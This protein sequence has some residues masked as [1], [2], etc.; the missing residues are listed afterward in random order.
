VDETEARAVIA[1]HLGVPPAMVV[2]A[3]ALAELGADPRDV[4][5]LVLR[6]ERC[7]GIRITDAQAERC[8][9]VRDLLDAVR[10]S[11]SLAPEPVRIGSV[12]GGLF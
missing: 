3:A 11:L 10:L 5:A 7:F 9:T 1:D 8:L 2:D 12:A 4:V 6:L